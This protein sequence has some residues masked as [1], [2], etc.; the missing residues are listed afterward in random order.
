MN[1][2]INFSII[3]FITSAGL[4]AQFVLATLVF[5][6]IA[7]WAIILFKMVALRKAELANRLFLGVFLKCNSFQELRS[8]VATQNNEGP[9]SALFSNIVEK[10][11]SD[12]LTEGIDI[13]RLERI[14][15]S[16]IQDEMDYY[17]KYIHLLAT[18]GNTSPFI[19]LFGTV[20]GIVNSF[21]EIGMQEVA[22]I[23]VVAPG[24]AEALI[25]TAAGLAAAIPAVIAFNIFVNKLYRL[26]TKL[27]V[28]ASE[29][30]TFIETAK[31][32][33]LPES[34]VVKG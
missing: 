28:F 8:K 17:Q 24:I 22:N 23:A 6:S 14:L 31:L 13:P 2:P 20:V 21:R 25:A 26:E 32:K 11:A 19:G 3:H 16:S 5:C 27:E 10:T 1:S 9:I 33:S 15:K 4:I 18:I 34:E 29:L 30:I 7:S 12:K